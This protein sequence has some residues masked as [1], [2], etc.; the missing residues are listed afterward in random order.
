MIRNLY[1]DMSAVVLLNG[2]FSRSFS[3]C[4]EVGQERIVAPFM[5]KVYIN[6]LLVELHESGLGLFVFGVPCP[7]DDLTL[8]I[9]F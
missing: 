8:L 4:Q 2:M 5:Y 3:I 7:A 6:H 1:C 9:H